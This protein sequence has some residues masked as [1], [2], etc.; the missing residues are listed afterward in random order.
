MSIVANIIKEESLRNE[1]QAFLYKDELQALPKGKITPKVVNNNTYYYLRFREGKKVRLKYIGKS[2]DD[3][4]EVEALLERRKH[5][6]LMLKEL[7]AEREQIRKL[8]GLI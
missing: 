5:I 7:Q 1:K 4:R 3:V 8:E 2:L 6:E